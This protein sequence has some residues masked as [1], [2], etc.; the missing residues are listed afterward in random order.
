MA[1]DEKIQENAQVSSSKEEAS[2]TPEP[3]EEEAK[4]DTHS[5]GIPKRYVLLLLTFVGFVNIYSMRVNLNVALVAMVNDQMVTS[6][7]AEVVKVT[8]TD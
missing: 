5:A 7:G 3:L 1:E 2:P 6:H 8:H 4:P